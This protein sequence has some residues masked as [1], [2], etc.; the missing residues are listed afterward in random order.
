M[1][2]SKLERDSLE[3]NLV[4]ERVKVRHP[5]LRL[6]RI[7]M[8]AKESRTCLVHGLPAQCARAVLLIKIPTVMRTSVLLRTPTPI[9]GTRGG[10]IWI[11][12]GWA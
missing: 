8:C 10:K 2:A 1:T 3:R 12:L 4:L 11:V 6:I 9:V 7:A 5:Q